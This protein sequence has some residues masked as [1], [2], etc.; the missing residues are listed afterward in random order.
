MK[1]IA[2][3]TGASSGM[4]KEFALQVPQFFDVDEIWLLAR[5]KDKLDEIALLVERRRKEQ[6]VILSEALA[7]SK[8]LSTVEQPCTMKVRPIEMD[9]AGKNGVERFCGILKEEKAKNEFQI[10]LLINNAGFGTYGTFFETPLSREIEMVDLNCTSVVGFTGASLPFM[11]KNSVIINTAS[12]A[13]FL[14]LGNFSIYAATKS[15]VL[16]FSVSLAAE[17]REKGIK[18]LALCPGPVDTEFANVASNGARKIVRHGKS[19]KKVVRH[20]LKKAVKGKKIAIMVFGWK[21]KA[22]ASRFVGRYFGAWFTYKFCKRPV[23][24]E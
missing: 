5:R 24:V 3:I 6:P 10:V 17:L 21:F 7:K 12:L 22:F 13:A 2:I 9:I 8:N 18:V 1:K 23:R 4:G 19:A 15:F 20:C 11:Q 16:S 14:P